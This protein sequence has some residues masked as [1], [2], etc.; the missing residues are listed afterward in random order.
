MILVKQQGGYLSQPRWADYFSKKGLTKTHTDLLLS[1]EQIKELSLEEINK[2]IEKAIYNNDYEFQRQMMI[3]Y[4]RKKRAEGIERLVYYCNNCGSILS[5]HG[6]GDDIICDHCGTIGHINEYE[7]IEGNKVDN[8]VDYNKEQYLHME[9]IVHSE[10]SFDV[11]LNLVNMKK[12]R[13][14]SL[15]KCNLRYQNKTLYLDNGKTIYEFN[16]LQM[17]SP[18]NTM[19]HSFSFDYQ[20]QTYNFTDIRHQFVLYEMLR[21]LNGSYKN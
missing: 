1:K 3:P 20:N 14:I 17:T 4:S 8:L 13:N 21:Y 10:F 9:E 12:R 15:G 18:V 16:M 7:F 19:R 5:V 2:T 11:T 6:E